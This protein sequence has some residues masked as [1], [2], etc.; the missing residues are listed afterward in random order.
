MNT[1]NYI[2]SMRV[3]EIEFTQILDNEFRIGVLENI[4]D[5]FDVGYVFISM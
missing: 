1:K 5:L 4:I 2:M 3:G